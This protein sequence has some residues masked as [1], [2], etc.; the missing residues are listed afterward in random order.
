MNNEARDIVFSHGFIEARNRTLFQRTLQKTQEWLVERNIPYRILGGLAVHSYLEEPGTSSINFNR[1][2]AASLIQRVPDIDLLV[3]KAR[4]EEV[5]LYRKA[6][7][8]DEE[9][10][11]LIELLTPSVYIDFRPDQEQSFL[12]HRALRVPVPTALFA[13]VER[14]ILTTPLTTVDPLTLFHTFVVC[15]GLLRHKDWKNILPL[16]RHIRDRRETA[17]AE[18]DFQGFHDFIARRREAYPMF[19]KAKQA[20]QEIA[21]RLPTRLRYLSWGYMIPLMEK[22]FKSREPFH[23][24]GI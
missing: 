18:A 24:D 5:K 22:V 13:P 20:G 9:L 14:T 6:V 4:I 2:Y 10:P 7:A 3:P 16:G 21:D 19:I 12:T 17:F 11:V 8:R 15:G 1:T 23:S